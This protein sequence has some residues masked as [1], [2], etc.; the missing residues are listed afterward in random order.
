MGAWGHGG[1]PHQVQ[2]READGAEP[3]EG[4]DEGPRGGAL[5][6]KVVPDVEGRG[7][8]AHDVGRRKAV[9]LGIVRLELDD[10]RGRPR[11]LQIVLDP[12]PNVV[13]DSPQHNHP[14]PQ[15]RVND[16]EHKR[17]QVVQHEHGAMNKRRLAAGLQAAA[18]DMCIPG[19]G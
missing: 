14:Q 8:A 10:G 7:H 9:L 3:H 2:A 13:R 16:P 11:Q 19:P 17:L 1:G 12:L 4:E 15:V 6:I 18:D 5:E